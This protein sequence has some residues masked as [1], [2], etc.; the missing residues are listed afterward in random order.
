M[1]LLFFLAFF[2]LLLPPPPPRLY[3]SLFPGFFSYDSASCPWRRRLLS[4]FRVGGPSFVL[5]DISAPLPRETDA[6]VFVLRNTST[7]CN[8]RLQNL[9]HVHFLSGLAV[10]GLSVLRGY[11]FV[12]YSPCRC[13]I[14][15]SC[16]AKWLIV[17][18]PSS[19]LAL[20]FTRSP[21]LG[22]CLQL[23]VLCTLC[24]T[25]FFLYGLEGSLPAFLVSHS[26][27][28]RIPAALSVIFTSGLA[29]VLP[30]FFYNLYF[31]LASLRAG[32]PFRE[33][34]AIACPPLSFPFQAT[35]G[36]P[37]ARSRRSFFP[38]DD[39]LVPFSSRWFHY[40][41]FLKACLVIFRPR[42]ATLARSR[43]IVIAFPV[44]VLLLPSSPTSSFRARLAYV[45]KTITPLPQPRF[46]CS[47]REPPHA[48]H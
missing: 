20:F 23:L 21:W 36:S 8:K 41:S 37:G 32:L 10:V 9:Q 7:A 25:N 5:F 13:F 30:D 26:P 24:T 44:D 45:M 40:F 31:P 17:S 4:R 3:T 15:W 47:D 18:F 38:F 34:V 2:A 1:I 35:P 33:R 42:L 6:S 14:V 27:L 29:L 16:L 12:Q 22:S 48:M 46:S 39:P 28:S 11:C 43:Q 19:P